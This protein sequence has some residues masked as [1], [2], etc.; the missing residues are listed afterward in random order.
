MQILLLV[1]FGAMG[2]VATFMLQQYGLTA[3]IASSLIGLTG[4]LIGML[5]ADV[6]VPAVV[7]AG[8]FA[9]MTA[10]RLGSVPL[11]LAAGALT[12]LI[13]ALT[14]HIFAGYGGRLGTTAFI[15]TAAI[16]LIASLIARQ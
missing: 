6:S 4:G 5:M 16:L 8:S 7:F 15:A 13:F 9:G 12:G 1:A 10:L 3:V 14:P 11:M 2:A